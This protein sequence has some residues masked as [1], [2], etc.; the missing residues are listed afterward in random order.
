MSLP[1]DFEFKKTNCF[2]I[3][4]I[5]NSAFMD[6]CHAKVA[7]GIWKWEGGNKKRRR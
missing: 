3:T 7:A 5:N 4:W 2:L 6:L 1:L